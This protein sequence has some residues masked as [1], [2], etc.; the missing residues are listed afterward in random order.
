[1]VFELQSLLDLRR[2][3]ES[4]ARRAFEM[5]AASLL[6]EEEE[7]A[8]LAGR[9]QAARTAWDSETRRLAAGP[10]PS[11]AE[12]GSAREAYLGRL[13]DEANRIRTAAEQHCATAL[14]AAQAAHQ[15][16]LSNHQKA[17]RDREAVSKLEERAQAEAA[18]SAARKA[19][20]A[21]TELATTQRRR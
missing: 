14:A 19:E 8:R 2:D 18:K 5:A 6:K 21:A 3:A 11:T 7:Q 1:M 20:D 17:A 12:Q 9:W 15:A 10:A 16:A 4:S 13:R